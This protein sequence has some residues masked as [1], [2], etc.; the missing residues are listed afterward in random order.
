MIIGLQGKEALSKKNGAD[1]TV[2]AIHDV[3]GKI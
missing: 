1:Y 2:G 3:L